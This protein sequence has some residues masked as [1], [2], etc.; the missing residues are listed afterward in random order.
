MDQFAVTFDDAAVQAGLAQE[1][2][3]LNADTRLRM[4]EKTDTLWTLCVE[5]GDTE[6]SDDNEPR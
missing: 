1:D 6:D 2:F 5:P 4:I 3:L